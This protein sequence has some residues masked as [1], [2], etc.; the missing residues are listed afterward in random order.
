MVVCDRQDGEA[1]VAEVNLVA[2]AKC[3]GVQFRSFCSGG[4]AHTPLLKG[5]KIVRTIRQGRDW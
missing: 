3:S 5:C 2:D 1:D 4:A